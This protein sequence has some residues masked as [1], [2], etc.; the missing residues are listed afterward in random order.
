MKIS[1]RQIETA[2]VESIEHA[3]I[4]TERYFDHEVDL[5]N[6]HDVTAAQVGTYTRSEIDERNHA[7]VNQYYGKAYWYGRKYS[8]T[9]WPLP[10][11]DETWESGARSAFDFSTSTPWFW[12][13]LDWLEE[14]AVELS[15]G[16]VIG[17]SSKFLDIPDSGFPGL[18]R[19]SMSS[20]A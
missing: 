15:N 20:N 14:T 16:K 5:N 4:A 1:R 19:Y 17:I 6:P 13:G 10:Y 3:A 18:A 12:D 7:V 8:F 9:P 2:L 11:G